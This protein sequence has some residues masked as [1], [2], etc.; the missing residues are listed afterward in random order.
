MVLELVI[1]TE[2]VEEG[3]ATWLKKKLKLITKKRN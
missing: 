1:R 3:N 2:E